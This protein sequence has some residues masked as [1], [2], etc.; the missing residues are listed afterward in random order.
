MEIPVLEKPDVDIDAVRA[1][2]RRRV[3]EQM[4]AADVELL[5]L[6]NPVSLRYAADWREYPLFQSRIQIYDLFVDPDGNMTMHGGY[7][8]D[9]AAVGEQ[10]PT[11]RLNSFDG[12]LELEEYSRRFASDV[13]TATGPGARIAVEQINPSVV[14]ALREQGVRVVDAEPLIE[15]ARYVKSAEE[16]QCLR[17]SIAVAEAAID[18]MR[19]A[20]EPGITENQ[21]FSLLHQ[22]NIANDGDWIDA[23]MLCSGPRTNPWYQQSTDRKI[24]AGDLVA[25]D[26]DMI[27]PFGYCADISRTWAV[28]DTPTLQQRDLYRRAHSEITHNA[29]LLE[30]GRTFREVSEK[31]F[32]HDAE[33]IAHRYTCLAHGV[34]LSDEYPKIVYR[35]DWETEGYDGEI[36]VDTVLS[37]ES[38]VGSE[39][40]GPGVK[41]EDMYLVTADGP[42]R[43]SSYPFEE[44]LL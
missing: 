24:A 38:F 2:R 21:L 19:S 3:L 41:L 42:E 34:G 28:D 37:V 8:S 5:V 9:G 17:H 27:G 43:L 22:V 20:T 16:I 32:Q 40:G 13:L 1:Y 31:A 23:R 14:V 36:M 44:E 10:H 26:T 35:Q 12:G 11:H 33:F 29:A 4:D 18:V 6:L 39:R 30:P 7:G 15:A 25:V